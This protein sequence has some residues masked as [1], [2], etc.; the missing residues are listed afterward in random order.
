MEERT[1]GGGVHGALFQGGMGAEIMNVKDSQ[2]H[3]TFPANPQD[4]PPDP[5]AR[6]S[7][8]FTKKTKIALL[9]ITLIVIVAAVVP[10][11]IITTRSSE[12]NDSPNPPTVSPPA[13][14]QPRDTAHGN[15]TGHFQS[16]SYRTWN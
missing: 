9:C 14:P 12:R 13:I 15:E 5:K 10:T 6:Q 1:T 2:F 16:T 3:F 4:P 7:F 11:T 8:T